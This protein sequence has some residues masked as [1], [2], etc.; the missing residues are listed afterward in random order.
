MSQR[1]KRVQ[2]FP[3]ETREYNPDK[4]F[5]QFSDMMNLGDWNSHFAIGA[6]GTLPSVS[7]DP[8]FLSTDPVAAVATLTLPADTVLNGTAQIRDGATSTNPA[9]EGGL[10]EMDFVAKVKYTR[11]SAV[12]TLVRVGF[13]DDSNV[14][15]DSRNAVCFFTFG[16]QANWQVGVY[17]NFDGTNG[18]KFVKDTGIS[19]ST[20]RTLSIWKSA[21]GKIAVFQIGDTVVHYQQRDLPVNPVQTTKY[22]AGSSMLATGAIS[23]AAS[24]AI[25]FQQFRYFANRI[26]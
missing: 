21:D 1:Q 9:I 15:P 22:R 8:I 2:S 14:L 6:T 16:N 25:D 23:A 7:F 12:N 26:S 18:F 5:R 4:C 24:L 10:C 11:G 19:N 3:L 13:F 17:A 20:W